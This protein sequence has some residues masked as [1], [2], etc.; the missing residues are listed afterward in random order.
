MRNSTF[1]SIVIVLVAFILSGCQSNQDTLEALESSSQQNN[2]DSISLT[3]TRSAIPVVT[4]I[5]SATPT[6][7]ATAIENIEIIQPT[8][9][10]EAIPSSTEK[11]P[12]TESEPTI[13]ATITA[14]PTSTETVM[15]SSA[16]QPAS[17]HD[18][19]A[20]YADISIPDDTL[21]QSGQ[22]FTKTWQVRNTGTCTW[23]EGYS[24][25]YASGDIMNGPL[26]NPIP[27]VEPGEVTDISVNLAAPARGGQHVGN[28]QFENSHGTR[29]GVGSGGHD[30]IWVQIVVDW[31]MDNS[32]QNASEQPVS[33]D[34]IAPTV[35]TESCSAA[36]NR[37]YESQVLKL[38][39][40]AR[41]SNGLPG[42]SLSAQLSDAAYE[43]SLDMGC[44]DFVDHTGTNGSTWYDRARSHGY[45]NYASARENIYVG[46]PAFGGA[47]DGAF[48]WWMNSQ[49]HR[50]NILAPNVSEVGIGY[51]YDPSSSYGGYYTVVF[52][53]P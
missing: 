9:S 14:M 32:S 1:I 29:F 7:Q 4:Q 34:T 21:M 45:A 15:I 3:Q 19:A 17:C 39:N 28:W 51:V 20:F 13:T 52:A 35:G 42:L 2:S 50:N 18:E 48:A 24:L 25:V 36:R 5:P 37:D 31:P 44:A 49:V 43:H 30:F 10:P 22:E 41:A 8:Q 27:K 23:D 16:L 11:A 33:T 38:V 53:R 46:D 6:H 47:P 40:E 26:S 12:N